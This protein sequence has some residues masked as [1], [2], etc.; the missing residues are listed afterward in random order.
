MNRTSK[1][2]IIRTEGRF[3]VLE[4]TIQSGYFVYPVYLT[5]DL[6]SLAM[7]P[8]FYTD[9]TLDLDTRSVAVIYVPTSGDETDFSMETL[10]WSA[11]ATTMGELLHILE[12]KTP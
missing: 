9:P 1:K 3:S 11:Y 5:E 12:E 2:Q 4:P 7:S 8:A 6:E 10:D